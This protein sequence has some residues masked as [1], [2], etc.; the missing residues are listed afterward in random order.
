MD[1]TEFVANHN[2]HTGQAMVDV[3]EWK[4][5]TYVFADQNG[6][7]QANFTDGFIKL[8]GVD[9]VGANEFV[10]S[11]FSHLDVLASD[12]SRLSIFGH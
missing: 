2:G 3:F 10:H 8:A 7:H 9:H 4:G 11:P 6:D 1:I 5:D 12:V